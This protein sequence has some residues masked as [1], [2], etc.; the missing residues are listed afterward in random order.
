MVRGVNTCDW[1]LLGKTEKCGRSCMGKYC[2]VHNYRISK[3]GGSFACQVC[4]KGV[5][6]SLE[7]CQAC[8]AK[9]LY[10]KAHAAAKKRAHRRPTATDTS[11]IS[12]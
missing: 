3:G 11:K 12:N 2:K 4:G 6:T 9:R 8:R 10:D 7:L 1:L 5:K